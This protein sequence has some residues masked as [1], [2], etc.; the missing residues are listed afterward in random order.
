MSARSFAKHFTRSLLAGLLLAA[1]LSGCRI[2]DPDGK[3][4]QML[5]LA[6]RRNQW[7]RLNIRDYQFDYQ[8]AAFAQIPPVT[9]YVGDNSVFRVTSKQTGQPLPNPTS[10]PT[11]DSLFNTAARVLGNSNYDTHI[12][13]DGT[14]GFPTVIDAGSMMPDAGFTI[15]AHDFARLTLYRYN[16]AGSTGP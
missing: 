14:Y 6:R 2:T 7:Q 11:I 12:N 10:Y 8:I 16:A 15:M 1:P 3:P 5:E 4:D 9:I 13:Y